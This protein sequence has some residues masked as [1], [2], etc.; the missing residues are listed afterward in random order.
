MGS[1]RGGNTAGWIRIQWTE[2]RQR[3]LLSLY[4]RS[5]PAK[6]GYT[7]RLEALWLEQ[8]PD[9]P[10]KGLSLAAQCRKMR[11]ARQPT[12][13]STNPQLATNA[14]ARSGSNVRGARGTG[15]I[16]EVV[17]APGV[18][19]LAYMNRNT[20][21]SVNNKSDG[22]SNDDGTRERNTSDRGGDGNDRNEN[23]G[24]GNRALG[25]DGLQEME[26]DELLEAIGKVLERMKLEKGAFDGRRRPKCRGIRIDAELLLGVD[27][28]ICELM[29]DS[30]SLWKLNCLVYAGAVVVERRV[31]RDPPLP[32]A[33]LDRRRIWI[34]HLRRVIGWLESEVRRRRT[35]VA[36]TPRQRH[37]L[38]ALTKIFGDLASMRKLRA[39]LEHQKSLLKVKVMQLRRIMGQRKR[40]MLN[41]QYRMLGPKSLDHHRQRD[42]RN[43]TRPSREALTEFWN[44]VIGVTGDF[45]PEDPLVR[46][47]ERDMDVPPSEASDDE[48]NDMWETAWRKSMK[49]ARSWKAPGNDGICAFW[50]KSFPRAANILRKL[51][52]RIVDRKEDVPD[53]LVRGRTV[54]IPKEGCEGKP[55]QYRPITCLNTAYKLLTSSLANVL[56]D[57]S[58]EHE[59]IPPEQRALRRGRRGCLDA[60]MVDFM[61]GQEAQLRGRNLSVAWI[62]YQK[63]YDRVPHGWLERVLRVVRAPVKVRHCI[64]SL[65]QHW[66]S[67]FSV[68]CGQDAV[69]VEMRYRRGLFQGDSLSPLLFCLCLAPLSHALRALDG[70]R[71][72]SIGGPITHQ[73]FMDDL[74]VYASGQTAVEKTLDT[75]DRVSSAIGMRLGLRKCAVAHMVKRKVKSADYVLPEGR[76]IASFENGG[77][78]KYLGVEQLFRPALAAVKQRVSRTYLKRLRKI[79]G[80]ELNAKNKVNAT[81]VWAVSVFRYFFFLKWSRRDLDALDRKTRAILRQNKSHQYGAA[82][83]RLYLPRHMGG[84]GLQSLRQVWEREMISLV[85]YLTASDDPLLQAVVIHQQYLLRRG[86]YSILREARQVAEQLTGVALTDRGLWHDD[87]VLRPSRAVGMLK[88]AQYNTLRE[89]LGRKTIHGKFFLQ[90][91]TDGWDEQGSHL[92]LQ[93]GKLTSV[94]EGL[95]LAAQ[96]GVVHTKAYQA[97]VMRKPIDQQCRVCGKEAETLGHLLSSCEPMKW[98][99]YKARHDRVLYQIVLLLSDVYKIPFPES[100]RWTVTGWSGVGVLE[101]NG[102]KLK[103]D[104]CSPTD[105]AL[106]ER[107]PDLVAFFSE[108]RQVV[109]MDV[110]CAWDPLI[111]E[112]EDEKKCKYQELAADL[113]VQN[114]GW[115]VSVVPIV[116]GDLGSMARLREELTDTNLLTRRQVN[117]LANEVQYESLCSMIRIVR[118]VMSQRE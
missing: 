86:K 3:D 56:Q 37:N 116:V 27:E 11:K 94:S 117:R 24:D 22:H 45:N 59:L 105:R 14:G 68:G 47:W 8:H 97:R 43:A 111:R 96:D 82:V 88:K 81:N 50:W 6:R 4:E 92:W 72:E 90:C 79:W 95:I 61:V 18:A 34:R 53:W 54:L 83:E 20:G 52:G 49:K 25:P 77:V 69:R 109:V 2:E 93:K 26:R 102:V 60:L 41:R 42:D 113:A 65:I 40:Q 16:R 108:T 17:T 48:W 87:A 57:H 114:P 104:M 13:V 29:G 31:K 46:S 107:R 9:L 73:L 1:S 7:S 66:T 55:E 101:G 28:A 33:S 71:S 76:T 10:S 75:V 23:E 44:S 64:S 36:L 106:H 110:A 62:D 15:G 80:S 100:M 19:S 5:E 63:A 115:Q 32:G 21:S 74:K 30:E 98:T 12:E 70:Y 35:G 38:R 78:Y 67:E 58:D 118:R 84:R 85:A 99:L 91:Q 51:V 112:R 103:V 39:T 89:R